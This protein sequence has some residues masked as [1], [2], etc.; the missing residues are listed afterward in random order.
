MDGLGRYGVPSTSYYDEDQDPAIEHD[1]AFLKNEHEI[2]DEIERKM[3]GDDGEVHSQHP[4]MEM[5]LM[6]QPPPHH[7]F[8]PLSGLK[9]RIGVGNPRM[10]LVLH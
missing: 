6:S 1:A 2:V 7:S 9:N 10:P 8:R 3:D 5:F 4:R